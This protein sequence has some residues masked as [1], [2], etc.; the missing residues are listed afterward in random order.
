[1]LVPPTPKFRFTHDPE[2]AEHYAQVSVK[3]LM[4]TVSGISDTCRCRRI[5]EAEKIKFKTKF[6]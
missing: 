2:I 5:I 1:M 3:F 6:P 4:Y